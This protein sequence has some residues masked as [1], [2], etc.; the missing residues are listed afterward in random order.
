MKTKTLFLVF[1]FSFYGCGLKLSK[2][3][4]SAGKA[5]QTFY[6]DK[7]L[8]QYFIS[9][10]E[11]RNSKKSKVLFDF[12][13]RSNASY[14]SAVIFNYTLF[15]E[16]PVLKVDSVLLI[17]AKDTFRIINRQKLFLEKKSEIYMIRYSST[18]SFRE[19]SSFFKSE[20]HILQLNNFRFE[21]SRKANR[22]MA[23]VHSEV[24]E[25]I[26]LS[27]GLSQ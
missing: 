9:P 23:S 12:T 3:G 8:I 5:Y 1:L 27:Q 26:E 15:S 11:I 20:K 4:S 22:R 19:L 18:I 10:I 21:S 17:N 6:I 16:T 14:D 7:G 2:S 24:I 13:F 25:L